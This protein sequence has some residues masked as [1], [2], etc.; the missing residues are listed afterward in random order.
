MLL[1]LRQHKSLQQLLI[2]GIKLGTSFVS[3][4][5]I[6]NFFEAHC[7]NRRFLPGSYF[8]LVIHS[9]SCYSP[10]LVSSFLLFI[11]SNEFSLIKNV[12]LHSLQQCLLC[13]LCPQIRQ[14]CIK[15]IQFEEIPMTAFRWRWAAVAQFFPIIECYS[16]HFRV[17]RQ[18]MTRLRQDRPPNEPRSL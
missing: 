1:Y 18:S 3:L 5:T 4:P 11:G 14:H 6:L 7:L 10:Y 13:S 2:Q 17:F 9:L 8:L 12:C 16:W 15:S